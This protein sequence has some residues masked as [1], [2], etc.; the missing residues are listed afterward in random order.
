M[1]TS[2]VSFLR[3]T[4]TATISSLNR[5]LLIAVS[6]FC[7]DPAANAS[8]SSRAH[9]ELSSDVLRSA[10]HVAVVERAPEAVADH[11]VDKLPVAEAVSV[12]AVLHEVRRARH[13]LHAAGDKAFRVARADRL[14]CK[15]HRLESAA[16]H[17]VDGGGRHA[18]RPI[19]RRSPIDARCS[20]R[21]RPGARCPSAPRRPNRCPRGASAS[22]TAIEPS[23]VAG[24]SVKTPPKVPTGV[25]TALT[26]TASSMP[27]TLRRGF[28]RKAQAAAERRRVSSAERRRVEVVRLRSV[29]LHDVGRR[30]RTH[31]P[32]DLR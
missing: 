32:G 8:W 31:A 25:R 4:G 19:R 30:E 6:A 24:T 20:D 23:L 14:R 1:S 21:G 17:L 18:R 2:T 26:M 29:L 7:C 5:P 10:A 27:A 3:C 16:A 13:V 15:R 28:G 11:L 12:P 22:S 9:L